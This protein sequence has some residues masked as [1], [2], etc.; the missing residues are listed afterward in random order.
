M[1]RSRNRQVAHYHHSSGTSAR[2]LKVIPQSH[3]ATPRVLPHLPQ[4]TQNAMF[5]TMPL[6]HGGIADL[7]RAWTSDAM[8]WLFPGKDMFITVHQVIQCLIMANKSLE[9]RQTPPVKYFHQPR[10][11]YR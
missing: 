8:I 4:G 7:F 10:M 3:R 1:F 11:F 2:L 9:D 5:T 6:Y